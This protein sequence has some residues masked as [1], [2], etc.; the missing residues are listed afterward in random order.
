MGGLAERG[1]LA[2]RVLC[3]SGFAL[4]STSLAL[5]PSALAK[6][7]AKP[8]LA[9]L[10]VQQKGYTFPGQSLEVTVNGVNRGSRA[11]K[12]AI[13]LGVSEGDLPE[14]PNVLAT[15]KYPPGRWEQGLSIRR[16]L[17]RWELRVCVKS[18]RG[19]SCRN[20]HFSVIPTS[21]RGTATAIGQETTG[22]ATLNLTAEPTAFFYF[23]KKTPSGFR[24]TGDGKVKETISGGFA[25][26]SAD[27]KGTYSITPKSNLLLSE[28]LKVYDA[29]GLAPV[30]QTYPATQTCFGVTSPP[31][32]S[33]FH[34]WLETG[35]RNKQPDAK[36]LA[37]TYSRTTGTLPLR[38][39]WYFRAQ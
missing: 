26:C 19:K 34:N 7:G 33:P 37:G 4:I 39:T 1:G 13:T 27:G 24:Y 11:T 2:K 20:A 18:K 38:W 35:P 28:D 9:I 30:V 14:L 21:W 12:A 25:P 5:A 8:D 3:L 31:L 22:G 23:D 16:P 17:G 6:K 15:E 29:V 10:S 36:T 32:E